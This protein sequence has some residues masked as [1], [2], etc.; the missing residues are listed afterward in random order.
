MA[1]WLK[2]KFALR[3]GKFAEASKLM[4]GV[5]QAIPA[6]SEPVSYS[7]S[8]SEVAHGE[9]GALHYARG[10][11]LDALDEFR[12]GNC[13]EGLTFMVES[14]LTPEELVQYAS[15]LPAPP[16]KKKK[17]AK[18][19]GE[20]E[21]EEHPLYEREFTNPQFLRSLIG[22]RLVRE[23]RVKESRSFLTEEEQ[24]TMDQYIALAVKAED[25]NVSA[26]ERAKAWWEAAVLM[27]EEGHA[28]R[29]TEED[30][31]HPS[32]DSEYTV[33]NQRLSG[34][35]DF[36]ND[37]PEQPEGKEQKPG[38]RAV[39]IPPTEDEK[40]RLA[41]TAKH[42]AKAMRT[43]VV[44]ANHVLAAAA[45]MANGSEEKARALNTAGHWLQDIDNPAADKIYA[46][47][48]K[49]CGSTAIGKAA[50]KKK[51]FLGETDPY[52]KETPNE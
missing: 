18:A 46:Q 6:P 16:K 52:T 31:H 15:K 45:L 39:F 42:H 10:E 51:W 30:F 14:I 41:A 8:T 38:K 23:G 20:E 36:E 7:P 9:T 21:T 13:G 2:A 40:K 22:R 11:Y 50:K 28:F 49:T 37:G 4:E 5:D 47:L 19:D 17:T 24:K 25:K 3:D 27:K 1:R 34:K 12:K 32:D 35:Y 33:R 48:Q 26:A 43:R 44:G 29:G